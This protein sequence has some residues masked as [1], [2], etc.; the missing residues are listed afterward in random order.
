VRGQVAA[1]TASSQLTEMS[2]DQLPSL[3]D[4]TM[5]LTAT[6]AAASPATAYSHVVLGF[7]TVPCSV[8]RPCHV[9][10]A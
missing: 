3:T 8:K 2:G 5:A 7:M 6:S 4:C 10:L 1:T 9:K